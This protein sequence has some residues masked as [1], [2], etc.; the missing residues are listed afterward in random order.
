MAIRRYRWPAVGEFLDRT[1]D[2]ARLEQWWDSSDREP[3]NLYGRRR[4]GKTWLFRRFADGKPSII[5][6]ADR[7]ATGAQLNRLARD[8]EP[9]LGILPDLPDVAA[10]FRALYRA[11]ARRK[12]LVVIDEFPYLLGTTAGEAEARLSSIQAA[13]EELRESS[14]IKLILCGSAVAQ[15]QRLQAETSPLHGRLVPLCLRPLPFAQTRVFSPGLSPAEQL[16][17][18]AIA[19]GMPRYLSALSGGELA[20]A[21]ATQVVDRRS[22]LF[23]EPR[24]LLSSELREPATY[25]A[26]LAALAEKPAEAST[27]AAALRTDGK[28]IAPHLAVLEEL[29]LISRFLPVGAAPNA[30]GC[31]YRCEDH[32]VRFWFRF[33]APYQPDLEA[34]ASPEAHI[35]QVVLP[36]L[37]DHTARVF[38]EA[39]L[40]WVRQSAAAATPLVG[41]WWG[42][43]LNPLRMRRERFTEEIDAVGLNGNQVTVVAEA[44]WTGRPMPATILTDLRDY[45]IPAL[46]QAGLKTTPQ[47]HIVLAS[48][49][50]FSS[51]L[52][53]L[54]EPDPTV[55]LI[56]AEE[57]LQ[58]ID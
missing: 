21:L 33:I 18:Y 29:R 51:G 56:Q 8:L 16:E 46:A 54:A 55:R 5:L 49:S 35:R 38:E 58:E 17:R 28:A 57:L 39:L 36:S 50:G 7:T 48:R 2:L 6:V 32:F 1:D 12:I 30:R 52:R 53:Q 44:K 14:K 9:A 41:P 15:M 40:V 31:R 25:F 45:K 42:P 10:L 23:N 27:I 47:P 4:V 37:A 34:G 3:L 11:A 13:L 22:P 20:A 43:S 19:G 26:I 24:T